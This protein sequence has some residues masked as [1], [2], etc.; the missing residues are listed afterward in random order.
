MKAHLAAG[1]P[2]GKLTMGMPFYGRGLESMGGFVNY[3]DMGSVTGYTE[4]WDDVAKVPYLADGSGK[5]VLGYENPQSLR[6]KC[7]YIK[8]NGLL[9]GMYW[10]Y[11]GDNASGDLRRAVYEGLMLSTDGN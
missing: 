4:K 10:D 1:V 6:I 11:D 3:K 5:L 8:D 9:G 7:R 2:A